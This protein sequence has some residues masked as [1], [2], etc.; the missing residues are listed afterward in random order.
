[1]RSFLLIDGDRNFRE[2]LAIALRLEGCRVAATEDAVFGRLALSAGRYDLCVVDLN[3]TGS[4]RLLDE[5]SAGQVAVLLTGPHEDLLQK[6]ARRHPRVRLL[7]K[8]FQAAELLAQLG[9]L[10]PA[11]RLAT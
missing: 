5:A 6:A 1:M 4:E 8:P 11:V 9:A 10:A 7:R 3:V 2:A